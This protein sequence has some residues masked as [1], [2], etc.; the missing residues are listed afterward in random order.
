MRGWSVILLGSS[1]AACQS[2]SKKDVGVVSEAEETAS[3]A[4]LSP[5]EAPMERTEPDPRPGQVRVAAIH[6]GGE[7]VPEAIEWMNNRGK[8][9]WVAE[10]VRKAAHKGAKLIVLPEVGYNFEAPASGDPSEPRPAGEARELGGLVERLPGPTTRYFSR[11]ARE[12]KVY[13]HVPLLEIEPSTQRF[14]ISIAVIDSRGEVI[15]VARKMALSKLERKYF[16]PGKRVMTYESPWG[17]VAVLSASDLAIPGLVRYLQ[18]KDEVKIFAVSSGSDLPQSMSAQP[19]QRW[20]RFAQERKGHL[21]VADSAAQIGS[22]VFDPSGSS[23]SYHR[24]VPG[25]AYGFLPKEEARAP[26]A[27]AERR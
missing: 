20:V 26:A 2:A 21:I 3:V 10:K 7:E 18:Q 4:S 1:L 12:L 8:R 22:G 27:D 9:E 11:L 15:G 14:F 5:F 6:F 19:L 23:Q 16:I 25:I 13:L 24:E 17:K